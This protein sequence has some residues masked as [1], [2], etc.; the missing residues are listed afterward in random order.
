MT[1]TNL[2]IFTQRILKSS[3]YWN[4][5]DQIWIQVRKFFCCLLSNTERNKN[6]VKLQLCTSNYIPAYLIKW[7][8]QKVLFNYSPNSYFQTAFSCGQPH[9]SVILTLV[10]I[11][12]LFRCHKAIIRQSSGSRQAV[13]RQSSGSHQAVVRLFSSLLCGIF[14]HRCIYL[15][16][17]WVSDIW[18][19][20]V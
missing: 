17:M 1:W 3:C 7:Q 16:C 12:E 15:P 11:F 4:S 5:T 14:C 18:C 13:V 2:H 9:K 20:H 19:V 10:A 8:L 6:S